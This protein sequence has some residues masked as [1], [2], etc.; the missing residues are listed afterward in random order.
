MRGPYS[1]RAIW[2]I[3]GPM[4]VSAVTT[5]LLGMVDT[6][7]VGH[8]DEPRFLAAV[9]VGAT[10]FTTLFMGL[11]FLRMGT[12][13]I[14]A[15]GF[16][17]G[18][19]ET[20]REALGQAAVTALVLAGLLIVFREPLLGAALALLE[21]EPGVAEL[22][23][24]YYRM[25]I[26]AAPA[27]LL[28]FVLIGWM[29]GMQDARGP[30]AMVLSINL[31]NIALDFWFVVG[32]GLDVRGVATATV[33]AE[34][35]GLGVGLLRVRATLRDRPGRWPTE[36]LFR[37]AHYARLFDVNAALFVR[38]MALMFVLA[39][40]TAR[41]ARLGTTVLAANALL[42]NFQ[43]LL[44]YALD[45]IA[46]AAEALVGRA[47]GARDR[48]GLLLAERRTLGWSLGFA[49]AFSVAYLVAGG[50]LIDRLT[51]IPEIRTAARQYLPWLVL[52]PLV[53]TWSF[54]YDG[55][56]VGATRSREMM[57]VMVAAAALVFLPTW[58]ATTGLGN[59]GLWLAFIAFM[60]AR[61]IGMAAGFRRLVARGQLPPMPA[62]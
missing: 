12:T 9:A 18:D 29:L 60:A 32:L 2:A 1:H 20:V 46:H 55:V 52:S 21:P 59:H 39:F 58:Y 27:A 49:S 4:I 17:A 33:V 45:G 37:P 3:A 47:V 42:M 15:Q 54:L 40:I 56:F 16:G 23:G 35:L 62:T 13:G 50:P 24:D 44:S 22:A 30:L 26:W 11:N 51:D 28:N 7:V 61:G 10:V 43:H 14:T 31:V 53:S 25:R 6:G 34:A 38:T 41:G 19:R 48:T 36:R 57:L 5:P 8:L